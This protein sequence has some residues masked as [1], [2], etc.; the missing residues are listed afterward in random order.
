MSSLSSLFIS[1]QSLAAISWQAF[2]RVVC[3]LLI[4]EGYEGVRL[5]GQSSDHGA[6]VIAHKYGKRW[7]FQIKRWKKSLD[8][9]F[10]MRRSR[11]CGYTGLLFQSWW[12]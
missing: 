8:P 7:L 3:R 11:P 1:E 5:V 4:A 9:R 6:D 10:W 2:E 12:H